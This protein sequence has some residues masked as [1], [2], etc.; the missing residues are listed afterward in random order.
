MKRGV[1]N[2]NLRIVEKHEKSGDH[3]GQNQIL[4]RTDRH[5]A[6]RL[7]LSWSAERLNDRVL[8]GRL[9]PAIQ[10]LGDVVRSEF[11]PEVVRHR[12]RGIPILRHSPPPHFLHDEFARGKMRESLLADEVLNNRSLPRANRSGNADDDHAALWDTCLHLND[13]RPCSPNRKSAESAEVRI[14]HNAAIAAAPL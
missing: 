10:F 2:Q 14:P 4:D 13:T 7:H 6:K 12:G 5:R 8:P 1:K 11:R 3:A 9:R